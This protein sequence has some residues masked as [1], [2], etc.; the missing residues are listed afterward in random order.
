MVFVIWRGIHNYHRTVLDLPNT[1]PALRTILLTVLYLNK[2]SRVK[3][4]A[5]ISETEP[6]L[7]HVTLAFLRV[8]FTCRKWKRAGYTKDCTQ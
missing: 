8:P 6:M 5:S 3:H 7:A 2:H 4:L 1:N